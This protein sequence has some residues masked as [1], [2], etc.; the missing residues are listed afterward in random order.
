M[1]NQIIFGINVPESNLVNFE[2]V[3]SIIVCQKANLGIF[4]NQ[5]SFISHNNKIIPWTNKIVQLQST[6]KT[7]INR[8]STHDILNSSLLYN[9]DIW[10]YNLHIFRFNIFALETSDLYYFI[11]P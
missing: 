8:N 2:R 6:L 1:E 10:F 5:L 11:F 3:H 4:I 9:F 7:E